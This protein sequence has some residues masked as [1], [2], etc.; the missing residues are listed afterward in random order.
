MLRENFIQR[1]SVRDRWK[2]LQG[3]GLKNVLQHI[4]GCL[5]QQLDADDKAKRSDSIGQYLRGQAPLIVPIT[6]LNHHLRRNPNDYIR[7]S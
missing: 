4:Q 7:D 5:R 2:T 3:Q 1:V 6:L